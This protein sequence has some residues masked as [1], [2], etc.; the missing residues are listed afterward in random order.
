LSGDFIKFPSF[1]LT[2]DNVAP[3][4]FAH[5]IQG[6]RVTCQTVIAIYINT[7]QV[8]KVN[9]FN[10]R[11]YG[12]MLIAF[13]PDDKFLDV[14]HHY[15]YLAP[16][17]A[18]RLMISSIENYLRGERLIR[19]VK[20]FERQNQPIIKTTIIFEDFFALSARTITRL[21]YPRSQ[22]ISRQITRLLDAELDRT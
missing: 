5:F 21:P 7:P 15:L 11:G 16:D 8:A 20:I 2:P 12:V 4:V 18:L 6:S 14:S 10:S 22:N 13:N 3:P 9:E 1:D 17:I 19:N